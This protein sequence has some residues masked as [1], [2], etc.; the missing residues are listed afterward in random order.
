[1]VEIDMQRNLE[2]SR[3]VGSDHSERRPQAA[4]APQCFEEVGNVGVARRDA[5]CGNTARA[6]QLRR[7][8]EQSLPEP[9]HGGLLQMRWGTEPLEP[10]QQVVGPT[11]SERTFP[12]DSTR[13]ERVGCKAPEGGWHMVLRKDKV[14]IGNSGIFY[15]LIADF[16]IGNTGCRR[17]VARV[18]TMWFR[19]N[20]LARGVESWSCGPSCVALFGKLRHHAAGKAARGAFPWRRGRSD[21]HTSGPGMMQQPD[22]PALTPN[23]QSLTRG[24]TEK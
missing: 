23:L 13:Y 8:Q 24:S 20:R 3:R 22:N 5:Q 7:N 17:R 12:D 4:D 18:G 9:L 6:H 21:C 14:E 11:R 16:Q 1:M 2:F 15:T 10:V 19:W